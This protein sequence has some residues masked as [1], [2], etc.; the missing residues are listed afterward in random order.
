MISHFWHKVTDWN[1]WQRWK[2][3]LPVGPSTVQ[4]QGAS[5]FFLPCRVLHWVTQEREM[6]WSTQKHCSVSGLPFYSQLKSCLHEKMWHRSELTCEWVLSFWPLLSVPFEGSFYDMLSHFF[7][8]KE[9]D[10]VTFSTLPLSRLTAIHLCSDFFFSPCKQVSTL[11][12]TQYVFWRSDGQVPQSSGKASE[13]LQNILSFR[14]HPPPF[15]AKIGQKNNKN[16]LLSWDFSTSAPVW[17]QSWN[18]G[19]EG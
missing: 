15:A 7:P 4:C 18:F 2:L 12:T 19:R 8:P 9:E 14:G 13:T 17:G 6:V 10:R 1:L 5:P 11:Q 3:C 16:R